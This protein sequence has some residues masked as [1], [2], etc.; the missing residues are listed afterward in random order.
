MRIQ[1]LKTEVSRNTLLLLAGFLLVAGGN[2]TFFSNVLHAFPPSGSNIPALASLALAF[3]A[4]NVILIGGVA[5]GRLT[6]PVLML[7][8]LVSS[9]T[10]Y[11]TDSFGVVI[12]DEML[13][14]VVQTNA[15]EAA[16]LITLKLLAYFVL[17]GVL[18][19]FLIWRTPLRWQGW[20]HELTARAK[21]LGLCMLAIVVMVM[22]FGSFYA[23]FIRAHKS[24]RSYANPA[25]FLVSSIKFI[26]GGKQP[27]GKTQIAVVAPDARIDKGDKHRELV[28]LVVGETARADRLSINGYERDTTPRLKE[29]QAISLSNF[30]SCGTS[31]A[32]S[33]PCMFSPYGMGRFNLKNTGSEEN[34]LDI[35]Q[36][37]GV[38]VL[39]LDN[40]SDSKGVAVR[41]P[42]RNYRSPENNTVCDSECRDEGMLVPLQEHIDRHPEGD[43]LIVLHQMG[44]HGPAYYKRYPAEFERHRP[45]CRH[46]DLSQCSREEI[47][48]AY[49][50]AILYTDH[51]LGKAVEL[52][53]RNDKHFETAL[54]YLSDHGESL[55]EG[56]VY[57]HGL[58]RAIA[59]DSQLHVPAILWFGSGFKELDLPSIARKRH[60]RFTHD[61][62]FHTLLG[63]FEVQ[64]TH[65]KPGLDILDGCRKH[66][67]SGPA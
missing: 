30:W 35:L 31:T 50:N 19:S 44:N 23:S 13:T 62:L 7:T 2:A 28:I 41:V 63:L 40:N 52:L 51:F 20:R 1:I 38:N 58:P 37:A 53:K 22:A 43:I 67:S 15:S 36:R 12:S 29:A 49:D 32:V 4:V 33:V 54:F 45:V 55:G 46:K 26:G 60:Q 16:D 5:L 48:N 61:H 21:L 47:G 27:A 3:F 24:L 56:G 64:S 11:F 66:D 42:Y 59:P 39:W 6:K 34:L 9:L 10:A 25:Y 17:L 57:L 8:L 14:N 18:P 65:Y